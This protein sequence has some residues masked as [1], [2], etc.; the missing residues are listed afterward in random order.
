MMETGKKVNS[1]EWVIEAI[2]W[3]T[4]AVLFLYL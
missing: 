2:T 1:A 4:L 3:M